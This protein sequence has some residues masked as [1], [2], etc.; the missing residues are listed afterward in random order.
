VKQSTGIGLVREP[1]NPEGRD[2]PGLAARYTGVAD[3]ERLLVLEFFDPTQTR[4]V[5]GSRPE[6]RGATV[7]RRGNVVAFY[8][9]GPGGINHV[10]AVREALARAPMEG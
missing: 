6:M 1:A 9:R 7:I 10:G 4:E 2:L 8:V 3:S 5:V